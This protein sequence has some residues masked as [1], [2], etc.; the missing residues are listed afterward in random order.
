[1]PSGFF[2][3]PVRV[4]NSNH[5]LNYLAKIDHLKFLHFN[6]IQIKHPI[7]IIH[8]IYRKYNVAGRNNHFFSGSAIIHP[9][10]KAAC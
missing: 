10:D 2:L 7:F 9:S 6:I 5:F 4:I 8:I 1:M 3:I